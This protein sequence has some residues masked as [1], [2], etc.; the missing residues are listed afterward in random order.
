MGTLGGLKRKAL[1]FGVEVCCHS[2]P[3]RLGIMTR[4]KTL[5]TLTVMI[6][7]IVSELPEIVMINIRKVFNKRINKNDVIVTMIRGTHFPD[8]FGIGLEPGAFGC[9]L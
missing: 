7:V 3:P 8:S 4:I 1:Q 5:T 6:V 9:R 2:P